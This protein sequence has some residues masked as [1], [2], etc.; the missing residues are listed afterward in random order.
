MKRY[1]KSMLLTGLLVLALNIVPKLAHAQ[2]D[3]GEDPDAPI[4]GGIGLLVVAGVGYGIKK[5]RDSRKK[6]ESK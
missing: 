6:L 2:V 3:P 1:T 4:D 5:A